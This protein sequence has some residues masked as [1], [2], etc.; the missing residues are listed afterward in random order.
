MTSRASPSVRALGAEIA[1]LRACVVD[2]ALMCCECTRAAT[3]TVPVMR[4]PC[5][6]FMY[7]RER[8]HCDR[9]APAGAV[10]LPHAALIRRTVKARATRAASAGSR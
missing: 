1:A 6:D 10:D 9:C 8:V 5:G 4:L 3:R 2:L 7:S